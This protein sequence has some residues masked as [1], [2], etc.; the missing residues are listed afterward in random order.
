MEIHLEWAFL[1]I[2]KQCTF[3][4]WVIL[5][6]KFISMHCSRLY[7][8]ANKFIQFVWHCCSLFDATWRPHRKVWYSAQSTLTRVSQPIFSCKP[9]FV[10]SQKH[11]TIHKLLK[12]LRCCDDLPSNSHVWLSR[13]INVAPKNVTLARVWKFA[14]AQQNQEYLANV[15]NDY[16][17]RSNIF[18]LQRLPVL[19]VW[20]QT[21][22]SINRTVLIQ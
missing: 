22:S 2:S 12:T 3:R 8:L 20:T 13:R 16:R 6:C 5:S 4:K 17:E 1:N 14:A 11:I 19:S 9:C 10:E 21:L 15:F 18:L 7:L